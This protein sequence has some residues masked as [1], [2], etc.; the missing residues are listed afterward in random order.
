MPQNLKSSTVLR[1]HVLQTV[2]ITP[3]ANFRFEVPQLPGAH[4]LQALSQ[5]RD[6][7]DLDKV[8]V[9]SGFGEAGPWGSLRTQWEMEA[10]GHQTLEGC[11]ETAWMMGYI[12]HFDRRLKD[13]TLHVGWADTK[14]GDPVNDKDVRGKYEY[15]S[16]WRALLR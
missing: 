8:I 2:N 5:L 13:G 7:I 14:I 6:I 9:T 10:K 16:R 1:L 4:T 3:R 15:E 12:E 11:I